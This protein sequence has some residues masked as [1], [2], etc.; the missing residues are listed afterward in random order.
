LAIADL[1]PADFRADCRAVANLPIPE[2][3]RLNRA[4]NSKEEHP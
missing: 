2:K 4:V 3:C 1:S